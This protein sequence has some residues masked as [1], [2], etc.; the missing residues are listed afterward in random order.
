MQTTLMIYIVMCVLTVV[1]LILY[2]IRKIWVKQVPQGVK[3]NPARCVVIGLISALIVVFLCCGYNATLHNRYE[4][5]LE[6]LATAHAEVVTGQRDEADFWQ[7]LQENGTGDIADDLQKI[8]L[9]AGAAKSVRF[10]LSS[11]CRPQYW[12]DSDLFVQASVDGDDNPLYLMY[13]LEFGGK[14]ALYTVRVRRTGDGWRYEWFGAGNEEQA[15]VIG[16]PSE[17]NGKWYTVG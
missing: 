12:Q 14:Q 15:K 1:P 11:A 13:R 9:S 5:A 16:L 4:I 8:D 3:F 7:L 17:I 6:R 2:N 10:Q